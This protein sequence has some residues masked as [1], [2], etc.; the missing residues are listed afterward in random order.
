MLKR[1]AY[2]K[3]LKWKN[4]KQGKTAMLIEG[5]RRVGKSTLADTFG[6]N[7]YQSCL[8]IDFFQAP[9]EVKQYFEDYRTDLDRLFLYLQAFYGVTLVE[10]NTLIVFDEVQMFP[11]ARGL[12]KY[13]VADGRYDYI[14]TGS[15]LSIKQNIQNIVLP[16]EEEVLA[17]EPIDFEEFLWAMGEMNL[18]QLI[19]QQFE[20]LEPLPEGLHRRASGLLREYM[21]VGGMPKAVSTYIEKRNFAE[22]DQEKRQILTLYRN[23]IA[24]FSR[25]YEFKV[26][27]VLDNIPGQLSKREKKFTLT[28]LDK[29][30]R[31]REY[32][33]AFFWLSD[34]RISNLCYASTDP[35][36]GLSLNK[37]YRSLKTYMADTGLLVTLAFADNKD[38]NEEV[39]RSILRG[40]IGVNEGM[41][42]ENLV[43]QM[44]VANGHRLF[45]YS[46]SGQKEGEAR[47]EIDFLISH[48]YANAA[49]KSRISPIEV[50]SPRQY[51]TISLDRFKR[52]FDKRIGMQYVLHPKQMKIEQDRIFLPLYMG[53]C[54]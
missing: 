38:T 24:R 35:I 37:N 18:G 2:D 21:L 3:L 13:L 42:V 48:S 39:Y 9:N 23:D 30:A 5:A 44:L 27:S 25:G 11:L 50:K 52:R 14:E 51:S 4:S 54:L 12:I 31:M 26:V 28:S 36:V 40:K 20:A 49:G 43:A 22:V 19:R 29:N 34:A 53:W 33:E 17:L 8:I 45:F 47:M 46:Q 6:K 15:L 10:R 41:L 1:K 7:E 16:S 32:E